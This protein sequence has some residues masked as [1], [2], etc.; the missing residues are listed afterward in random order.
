MAEDTTMVLHSGHPSNSSPLGSPVDFVR[1]LGRQL[2]RTAAPEGW[3]RRIDRRRVGKVWVGFFHLW[4]TD[5]DGRRVRQQKEKTLGPASL[6]KHEA[7]QKLADYIAEYTGRLT[8]QGSSIVTFDDLWKTF[9]DVK[10]GQWSKKFREDLR[11]LFRKHVLPLVGELA[12]GEVTLTSLQLLLNKLAEDGYSKSALGQIR[13][14]IK[15][16]F[17]YATDEDL[18]YK[19]PA[20]K[21]AMPK[22]RK[23]SCGRFLSLEQ[24][25]AL[26]VEASPREHV[27][28]RILAV[29]GLQ[30]AEV[31][32]LRIEDFEGN[33]LRI[34]EALKERHISAPAKAW[35]SSD[36]RPIQAVTAEK[37]E[38]QEE[39]AQRRHPEAERIEPGKRH[40]ASADHER[41]QVV[42]ESENQRH[43]NE[44]DHRRS[45]HGEHAVEN[46]GRNKVVVR[47][48]KLQ[49]HD[50]GFDPAQDKKDRPVQNVE[51]PKSLVI[52]RRNPLVQ[53]QGKWANWN[54]GY[55]DGI[56]R[57]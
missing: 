24:L 28:L 56:G 23:K 31:L 55:R 20:R 10:A 54:F 26:L 25:N 35:S 17:E 4:T 43:G 46:L 49:A 51:D 42:R 15:A 30:P 33:Q 41:H 37:T 6:P 18:I 44:K 52:H 21:L 14:Y 47:P 16:C 45:M 7:Q 19:N 12:L 36:E 32:V 13:T 29:C 38:I 40:I 34:D 2:P 11:Y 48:D 22:V 3:V 27:I 9:S 57:H 50:S 39:T 53:A 8:K 1:S 5:A